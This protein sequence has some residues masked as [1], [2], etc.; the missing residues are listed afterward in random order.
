MKSSP[1]QFAKISATDRVE[2]FQNLTN[3]SLYIDFNDPTD[4]S[5]VLRR[6]NIS[7]CQAQLAAYYQRGALGNQENDMPNGIRGKWQESSAPRI[8]MIQTNKKKSRTSEDL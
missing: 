3:S 5:K 8:D 4:L 7:R 2:Y 1:A 6:A